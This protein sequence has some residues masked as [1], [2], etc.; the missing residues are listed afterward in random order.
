MLTVIVQYLLLPIVFLLT[1]ILP[2]VFYFANRRYVWFSIPLTVLVELIINWGNFC[3]YESRGLMIFVTLV[4]V[5]VMAIVVLLLK[6]IDP[7]RNR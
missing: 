6:A 5:A 2:I 4:Q 3:Y 1:V 7:K